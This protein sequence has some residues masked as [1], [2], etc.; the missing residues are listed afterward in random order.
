MSKTDE[1]IWKRE[2]ARYDNSKANM[3]KGL[4]QVYLLMWGQCTERLHDKVEV[5]PRY[6]VIS[7]AKDV[8]TMD[9]MIWVQAHKTMDTR[10]KKGWTAIN[11]KATV[12][13]F[14]EKHQKLSESNYYCEFAR[15]I[16][17]LKT[18]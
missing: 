18:A 11:V 10:C 13:N 6:A 1:E 12:I 2:V 3:D 4:K 14:N 5:G 16:Q 15:R 8:F 17:G 7:T 9:D